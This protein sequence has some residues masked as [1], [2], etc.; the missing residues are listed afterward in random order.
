MNPLPIGIFDSG[1]GGLSVAREIH[2][3]LPAEPLLYLA[4]TAYCPYGG[5]SVDEIRARSVAAVGT[6]YERGVKAVVV[7]CNTAT[8]AALELLRAEFPIPILGLEPAVKPAAQAT[9]VGRV[10]VMATAGTLRSERFGRLVSTFA[11]G[12]EVFAVA[13]PGLVELVEAGET[14]GELALGALSELLAPLREAGVD[15]IVLGCT[16]YPF[17]REAVAEVMGSGVTLLDSG[18]AVANHL[19]RVLRD[20]DALADGP[21]GEIRMLT[22]GNPAAVAT[23]VQRL[24]DLGDLARA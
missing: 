12:V 2:S 7:A 10:G 9:R 17:L 8:G 6:L 18:R 15:T 22:T 4:D 20:A 13:C 3:L 16:H 23:V 5:R 19:D 14:E 24:E 1:V 21:G 11:Q